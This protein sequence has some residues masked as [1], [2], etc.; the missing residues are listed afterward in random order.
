MRF[1]L[2]ANLIEAMDFLQFREFA[3]ECIV[4]RG[5]KATTSDGWSDGGRDIRVFVAEGRVSRQIAF[6]CS[7]EREWQA[8]LWDDLIKAKSKL[9]CVDFT[10]VTNR[11]IGD[12]VFEPIVQRALTDEG[13]HLS[14]IDK[15][16]LAGQILDTDKLVWFI[17]F[18]GMPSGTEAN[19]TPA[20]LRSEVADAFILFS[21]DANDF[22]DRIAEHSLMVALLH[23]GAMARAELIRAASEIMDYNDENRL[24]S[25]LDR[26]QQN[27]AVPNYSGKFILSP[28]MEDHYRSTQ[29][30]VAADRSQ[31]RAALRL[32]LSA[33]LLPNG[34]LDVAIAKVEEVLLSLT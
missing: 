14:K 20:S 31:Y 32:C 16:D 27:G 15:Q 5:Y 24:N 17:H 34:D 33:F 9:G 7:V 19:A 1:E 13:V 6:Q 12:A 21:D 18:L 26:L 22:R 4:Q 25:A 28:E 11:R 2:I 8:K 23:R 30:L 29:S 3:R 10:Y